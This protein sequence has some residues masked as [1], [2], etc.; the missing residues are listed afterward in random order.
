MPN[1]GGERPSHVRNQKRFKALKNMKVKK[2]IT[3]EEILAKMSPGGGWTREQLAEWGVSWPPPKG[4]KKKI[5]AD[6]LR[7]FGGRVLP[8][9]EA[10]GVIKAD[11]NKA[12]IREERSR[13]RQDGQGVWHQVDAPKDENGCDHCGANMV[14]AKWPDGSVTTQCHGCG[15]EK[16]IKRAKG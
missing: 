15:R 1:G 16:K 11:A 4:W 3:E 12:A 7:I 10:R 2:P 5:V 13:W 9:E 6:A 8:P 14:K